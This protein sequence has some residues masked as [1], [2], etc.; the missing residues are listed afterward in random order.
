MYQ[1]KE[2]IKLLIV[3]LFCHL[4]TK[5]Y[6][7]TNWSLFIHN[8]DFSILNDSWEFDLLDSGTKSAHLKT[9]HGRNIALFERD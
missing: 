1:L 9:S 2:K 4:L 8:L 6:E 5:F 3:M 7:K